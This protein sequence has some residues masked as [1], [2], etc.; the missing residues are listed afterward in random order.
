MEEIITLI[1]LFTEPSPHY[2]RM[3]SY[4]LKAMFEH[5]T[6]CYISEQTFI[7]IML[8]VGVE[9]KKIGHHYFYKLRVKPLPNVDRCFWGRGNEPKYL[10]S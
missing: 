7:N 4:G 9:R 5:L 8:F 6:G 3:S 1:G 10:Q 2:H